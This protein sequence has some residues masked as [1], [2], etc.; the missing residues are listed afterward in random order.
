MISP[1]LI[2]PVSA[3][4]REVC[5]WSSVRL[6]FEPKGW[7]RE[8]RNELRVA[9]SALSTTPDEVLQA[10]YLST[11]TG[12][13]DVENVLFYNVGSGCFAPSTT[14]GLRFEQAQVACLPGEP[15]APFSHFH[16]YAPAPHD[17]AFLKCG[18]GRTIARWR[19]SLGSAE[20]LASAGAVWLAL[21]QGMIEVDR[22][23]QP[24]ERLSVRMKL[25]GPDP[26]RMKA[27]SL[28]KP[29]IDGLIS[30]FHVHNGV[31]LEVVAER[32]G[33]Q[34]SITPGRVARLL[35]DKQHEVLGERRL[36]WPW[37][38]RVQW[39][40][41]D[42]ALVACELLIERGSEWVLSGSL[43]EAPSLD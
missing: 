17:G 26:Q 13:F 28:V 30:A 33:R 4:H 11:E 14:N 38:D 21:K 7:V 3:E 12:T 16:Q 22:R 23:S 5:L 34:L 29:L 43:A 15:K 10:L 39:N 8:M 41:A 2:T 18:E 1:Y 25:T 40:P 9:V 36:L 20:A 24:L 27:T 35:L 37:R 42:D 31:D 32:L 6:P 19:I